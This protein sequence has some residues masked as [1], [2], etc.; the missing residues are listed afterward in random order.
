MKSSQ[1]NLLSEERLH[2]LSVDGK[3]FA[4]TLVSAV[5]SGHRDQAHQ[6]VVLALQIFG[7]SFESAPT[8]RSL[9]E[10]YL[11]K[12]KRLADPLTAEVMLLASHAASNVR[13]YKQAERYL[14]RVISYSEDRW[15][16]LQRQ[17]IQSLG[18]LRHH[19]NRFAE[20]DQL[21]AR[22]LI[23]AKQE[24]DPYGIAQ[25]YNNI[26]A[27]CID[28]DPAKAV[29]YLK[30][31]A[32]LK[33]KHGWELNAAQTEIAL[34]GALGRLERFKEAL[35]IIDRAIRIAR[36]EGDTV[37]LAMAHHNKGVVLEDSGSPKTAIPELKRGLHY[38]LA[39]KDP[40][41]VRM[42]LQSLAVASHRIGRNTAAAKAFIQLRT[43]CE[44]L[45]DKF[46]AAMATHDCGASYIQMQNRTAALDMYAD[47]AKQFGQISDFLWSSRCLVNVAKLTSGDRRKAAVR[48][49]LTIGKFPQSSTYP[50]SEATDLA[51]STEDDELV[52]EAIAVERSKLRKEKSGWGLRLSQLGSAQL[53][54]HQW[55][56]AK[57]LLI[58]SVR[59]L[60]ASKD[61]EA[62]GAALNDA[63]IC[64]LEIGEYPAA[65]KYFSSALAIARSKK[66]RV[67]SANSSHNL[68]EWHRR[69]GNVAMSLKFF[70]ESLGQAKAV[71]DTDSIAG[72]L[73][74]IGL[75][76]LAKKEFKK[77]ERAFVET[78][79]LAETLGSEEHLGQALSGLGSVAYQQ[80]N[81]HLAEQ[82][83]RE[84]ARHFKRAENIHKYINASYEHGLAV[85]KSGRHQ[86]AFNLMVKAADAATNLRDF[87]M[88][89]VI[90]QGMAYLLADHGT[91]EQTAKMLGHAII[92]S[93]ASH[94]Q[95]DFSR[96]FDSYM[97]A[98]LKLNMRKPVAPEEFAASVM[99]GVKL[100]QKDVVATVEKQLLKA[101]TMVR[102]KPA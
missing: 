32:A 65:R 28:T 78:I 13:D 12:W 49:L 52:E 47:A 2:E 34:V 6:L 14:S 31:S 63:G 38:S 4:D 70:N 21:Y 8:M 58:E 55:Q 37:L 100:P 10:L 84:A 1:S 77:A 79:T 22:A 83:Y 90:L 53:H 59:V 7:E 62:T 82:R 26:G 85:A 20:R 92:T 11:R 48:E 68:G 87:S 42:S 44:E 61:G 89:A 91:P 24:R 30:K 81:F 67:L 45:D 39:S 5:K 16:S 95:T 33:H 18:V 25:L 66:N 76:R 50:A 19:Q 96:V 40:A 98:L 57:A 17:S 27:S 60:R 41:L 9:C 74:S 35:P 43:V 99:K 56:S 73:H 102:I 101:N 93:L 51:F 72:T 75:S 94:D 23:I 54:R 86:R 29:Q 36:S 97:D 69:R 88:L 64:L 15:P 71:N 80:N 46:G 3:L